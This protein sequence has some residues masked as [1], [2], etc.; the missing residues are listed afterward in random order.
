MEGTRGTAALAI[1][2]CAIVASPTRA[3]DWRS[4]VPTV[5]GGAVEIVVD[6]K[7]LTY[8]TFDWKAPLRFS[9]EGPTRVKILTRL[10]IPAG[11]D[12]ESYTVGVACDGIETM[13]EE[14]STAPSDRARYLT[15][16]GCRPGTIRRIYIDVPT[17]RHGYEL[18]AVRPAVVEARV[19]EATG[20]KPRLA[21]IAPREYGSVETLC[22]LDKELTY[23][24]L[25]KEAPVVLEIIGPTSVKVN[26]R[27]LYDDTMSNS[28]TYVVG[29]RADGG[30]ERLYKIEAVR[31]EIVVCRDR[32]NVVPGA[33]RHFTL[34]VGDGMH[35]YEFRLVDTVA[36]AVALKFYIP[37]GD[38]ANEP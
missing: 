16:S 5:S 1:L 11:S 13:M 9:V 6:S 27:L 17:G 24:V 28:Q 31:S 33:L 29:V 7:E 12:G 37:R 25:T 26:T 38:L 32:R 3:A 34:A 14:L 30:P 23:Y 35:S 19:F 21:S 36:S 2:V 15:L 22:Y 18:R 4:I 8:H 20:R 10:R